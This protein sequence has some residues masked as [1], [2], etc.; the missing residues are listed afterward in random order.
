MTDERAE[1]RHFEEQADPSK[2]DLVD[3]DID[4]N[5]PASTARLAQFRRPTVDFVALQ[6][7]G[8]NV[9][10][11]RE[12]VGTRRAEYNEEVV[13]QNFN[14]IGTYLPEHL[15]NKEAN[16]PEG[17]LWDADANQWR[18]VYIGNWIVQQDEG[19]VTVT[20][21]W[22]ELNC[23]RLDEEMLALI[24][25][26]ERPKTFQESLTALLNH[27]SMENKTG[28]P[29]FLLSEY[30]IR[31][32][33]AFES[34]VVARADW[35]GEH[36]ELPSLQRLRDG[37]KTVPVV[38]YEGGLKNTIGEAEV[39]ITPG[40][41]LAGGLLNAVIPIFLET[42]LHPEKE[43]NLTGSKGFVEA[44]EG[45]VESGLQAGIESVEEPLDIPIE[46][47]KEDPGP[48]SAFQRYQQKGLTDNG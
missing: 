41:V 8:S 45:Q 4:A 30:L 19:W 12:H 29:D 24:R 23:I 46:Q 32:L 28:T 6:F 35:R 17:E 21:E 18:P 22:L 42:K 13:I 36:T 26:M 38:M 31:C 15:F 25:E 16:P 10:E 2:V 14:P 39:K 9:D 44:S 11:I 27:H 37:V 20:T 33:H 5:R 40:E 47:S 1:S 3:W 34:I 48:T 7:T 43:P